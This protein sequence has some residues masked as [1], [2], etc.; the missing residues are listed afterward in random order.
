M[1]INSILN[2]VLGAG[3]QYSRNSGGL[4]GSGLGG[5][6]QNAAGGLLGGA[7][8]GSGARGGANSLGGLLQNSDA[9]KKIGGGA[10]AAGILS[11]IL[12]GSNGSR[13][14]AGSLA[15]MGSLAA[16]GSLAYQAY[17]NWQRSN[18]GSVQ[19]GAAGATNYP[20]LRP[21]VERGEDEVENNSRLIL[22][23]MIA[24][25]KADGE[26]S[27]AEEEAIVAQVGGEDAEVQRW[28]QQIVN[29]PPSVQQIAA[30][31]GNDQGLAAE[32]YLASRIVCGDLDRKEI[33]YLANLQQ[34]LGLRDSFVEL[35]EKQ[36][37]L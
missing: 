11:M 32:I 34:A 12:G 37:G 24:A 7:L 10:A 17:Q 4:S 13:G 19:Q 28:L 20:E 8:G 36:A 3:Q 27:A 1:N 30:E 35:L 15:K 2:Q 14:M 31:V 29:N 18:Q 25:A 23:A 16:V 21:S 33:V 22:K 5:L 6:L 26:I 9:L